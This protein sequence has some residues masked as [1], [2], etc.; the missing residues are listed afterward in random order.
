MILTLLIV[1]LGFTLSRSIM[2]PLHAMMERA[3]DL[4]VD[5][6]D[7]TRRLT[8]SSQDEFGE[9]SGWFNKF[10]ERLHDLVLQVK[11]SSQKLHVN[12]EEIRE[13]SDHLASRT[14]EQA[15]SITETSATLEAFA[16]AIRDNTE[17]SAEADMMLQDFNSD[18]QEKSALINNVTDTMTE[19]YDS[20]QQ[21]DNIIRVINDISFQTNLLALNAAVEA[22]RAGEA[23]RGFAVVAAEVRNLAQKTAESS[24]SIR[25]I[26]LRNVESTQKGMKLVEATSTFFSD[27]VGVM[28][29][30]VTKITNITNVSREQA[31]GIEQ[32]SQTISQMEHVI[33]QNADMVRKL[34]TAGRSVEDSAEAL[35]TL[36]AQ[37]KVDETLAVKSRGSAKQKD[38]RADQKSPKIIE[39][40]TEKKPELKKS[41]TSSK[42]KEGKPPV[43]KN[44]AV[45]DKEPEK[46]ISV[47]TQ[48]AEDDFFTQDEDG[49]QE[50]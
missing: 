44:T 7:M 15:A 32:I 3:Y 4:A 27:I 37:F 40:K 14:S 6:V 24:K 5:D 33:T 31:T 21:I 25:E 17:N 8:V 28:G 20:S 9:L 34:S 47:K 48:P 1:V 30:I 23:G 46:K 11:G 13:G 22:A 16:A 49:F 39:K 41:V 10:L 29:D 12:T 43:T 50:F 42:V 36:T 26:V 38:K 18:I 2:L 45:R 19:I 35:Q